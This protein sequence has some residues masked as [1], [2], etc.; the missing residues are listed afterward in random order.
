MAGSYY[1]DE[2]RGDLTPDDYGY[3][4]VARRRVTDTHGLNTFQNIYQADSLTKQRDI[5]RQDLMRQFDRNRRKFSG[6]YAKGGI[7]NSGIY[8]RHLADLY[9]DRD[10]GLNRIESQYAQQ[11]AGLRLAQQQLDA[12]KDNSLS[13]IDTQEAARRAAVA[14]ALRGA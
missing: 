13:D 11:L 1:S 9:S 5:S 2:G 4:Q 10:Y 14:A 12:T 7:M 3:F 6:G 8:A